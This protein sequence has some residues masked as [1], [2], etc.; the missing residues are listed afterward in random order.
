MYT[1]PT[2][3]AGWYEKATHFHLQRE[4]AQKIT[5][6][7]CRTIVMVVDTPTSF[8][9]FSPANCTL[10][11]HFSFNDFIAIAFLDLTED[12]DTQI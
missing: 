4:I 8:S 2:T 9:P 3:I 11:S 6:I 1:V 7:H 10:Y 5:V 12:L